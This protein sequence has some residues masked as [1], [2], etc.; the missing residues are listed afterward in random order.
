MNRSLICS[1]T[2][3]VYPIP[4]FVR[5]FALLKST[6]FPLQPHQRPPFERNLSRQK[7]PDALGINYQTMSYMERRDYNPSIELAL[8]ASELFDL[9]IDAIFSRQP[10]RPLS[11]QIYGN[12]GVSH[13]CRPI[14]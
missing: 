13:P 3:A 4:F 14:S 8:R 9:P 1:G 7:L 11:E 10:F 5:N 6:L 2:A 12:P